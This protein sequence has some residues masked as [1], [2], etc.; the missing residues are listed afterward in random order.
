VANGVEQAQRGGSISNAAE[1]SRVAR[2]LGSLV[3]SGLEP[4]R[5]GVVCMYRAQAVAI[6]THL[7]ERGLAG[8][9]TVSTVDAFQGAERDVILVSTCL[10]ATCGAPDTAREALRFIGDPRRLNVTL[11]RARHH[12][13]VFGHAD[14]LQSVP[15]WAVVLDVAASLPAE[16]VTG[17]GVEGILVKSS[18]A[19]VAAALAGA[20]D[21][22]GV[23]AADSAGSAA[24]AFDAA[25]G[26]RADELQ[27]LM[28]ARREK[29]TR[30]ELMGTRMHSELAAKMDVGVRVNP[31][32]RN[33]Y[34]SSNSNADES[35]GAASSG[36]EEGAA[37]PADG[38]AN[39]RVVVDLLEAGS[40]SD[41]GELGGC[42]PAAAAAAASDGSVASVSSRMGSTRDEVVLA[43][44][45]D[46]GEAEQA[47]ELLDF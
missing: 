8:A 44:E 38:G 30:I 7:E 5:L 27:L 35:G 46:G 16:F 22:V 11:T 14:V 6:R 13:L 28:A 32:L 39:T 41:D 36:T 42:G 33:M 37:A 9:V 40:E 21:G 26:A 34:L 45:F 24:D 17:H 20:G 4:E 43:D 23:V 29:L 2:V 47:L 15:A 1:A 25:Q 10:T 12:L 19:E 31:M 18:D 3:G